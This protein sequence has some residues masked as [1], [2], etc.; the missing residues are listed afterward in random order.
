[1]YFGYFCGT[2]QSPIFVIQQASTDETD[3]SASKILFC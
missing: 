2:V 1:M 3:I